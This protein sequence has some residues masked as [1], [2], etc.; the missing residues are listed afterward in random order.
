M[1]KTRN[2]WLWLLGAPLVA[3][4]LGPSSVQSAESPP[5]DPA[6][7]SVREAAWR[8][9]FAGDEAQ[10]RSLLPPEFI[11]V[12][13]GD[14]PLSD[15][16]QTLAASKAFHQGGGRLVKLGFPETR[17]QRFGDVVVLYGRFEAVVETGGVQTMVRGRLTET[18][19]KRGG[20]WVHPGW[21]LDPI[22]TP[23]EKGQPTGSQ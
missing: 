7:L 17:A 20:K 2:G 12:S 5:I 3:A 13:W 10:L 11:G 4:M 21:H 19:V 8:A 16:E 9:W 15:L 18:F 14:G 23:A 1:R 6:L 22:G